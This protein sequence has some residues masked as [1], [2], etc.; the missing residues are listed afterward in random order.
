MV[1][2][3]TVPLVLLAGAGAMRMLIERRDE[4]LLLAAIVAYLLVTCSI[5]EPN[6]RFRVPMMPFLAIWCGAAVTWLRQR[7]VPA[8]SA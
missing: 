6:A 5:A 8:P 1:L 4:G 2:L 3:Y 7:A